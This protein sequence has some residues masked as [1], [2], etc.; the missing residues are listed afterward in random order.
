[1][2]PK[3]AEHSTEDFPSEYDDSEADWTLYPPMYTEPS[4]EH[5]MSDE[6]EII[7][8]SSKECVMV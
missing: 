2:S 7:W 6:I 1:M 3:P 5:D 4:N 8:E